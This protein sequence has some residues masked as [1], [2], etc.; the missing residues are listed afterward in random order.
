MLRIALLVST[1]VLVMVLMTV[2]YSLMMEY[3]LHIVVRI[4]MWRMNKMATYVVSM[5][6]YLLCLT[7]NMI[8][9]LCTVVY[10]LQPLM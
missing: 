2:V 5:V 4:I 8:I 6:L 3:V 1:D 7:I 10:S 9:I